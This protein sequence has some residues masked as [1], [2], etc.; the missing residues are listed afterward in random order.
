MKERGGEGEPKDGLEIMNF[1]F[2]A[3][4]ATG[5]DVIQ[6]VLILGS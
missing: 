6:Q 4:L 1:S 3:Q 5:N 2:L